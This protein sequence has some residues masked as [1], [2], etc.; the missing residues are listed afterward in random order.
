MKDTNQMMLLIFK[1]IVFFP[2][3]TYFI[4][5]LLILISLFF[6]P[7]GY[8][9]IF[10]YSKTIRGTS[11]NKWLF[12]MLSFYSIVFFFL[13][14]LKYAICGLPNNV[15]QLIEKNFYSNNTGKSVSINKISA[16]SYVI[17]IFI[18]A[19]ICFFSLFEATNTP[20]NIEDFQRNAVV[21][22]FIFFI[23]KCVPTVI[24]TCFYIQSMEIK[25]NVLH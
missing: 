12:D 5:P 8:Q 6:V 24:A 19:Y 1:N 13:S 18:L 21:N 22:F 17:L 20:R 11:Q 10:I 25:R 4:S 2:T 16:I 15:S 7:E 14:V 3:V 23:L 9:G